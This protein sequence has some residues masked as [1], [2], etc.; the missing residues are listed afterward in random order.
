[1]Y[2]GE[3]ISGLSP[4]TIT[5]RGIARTFQITSIFPNLTITENVIAGMYLKAKNSIWGSFF[6]TKAC[7]REEMELRRKAAEILRSTLGL[8]NREDTIA[9]NSAIG[10]Q[11]NLEI[12][13][14]LATDPELLLLDEPAAGLNPAEVE[15]LM[16]LLISLHKRGVTLLIVEH[17]MKMVM[18]LCTRIVV[19]DY[20]RKIAEGTPKEIAS[21]S[22]V[23][24][25]YLGRGQGSV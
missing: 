20:G 1:M 16:S 17:N 8:Q 9:K 12:A 19:L 10:E 5:P 2:R 18:Q 3:Q 6:R 22:N 13:I 25:I 4:Y 11:R 24:S 21:N 14:A 7:R 15:Q 23:I